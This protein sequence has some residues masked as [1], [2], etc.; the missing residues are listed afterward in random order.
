MYIVYL[1]RGN[2]TRERE[3]SRGIILFNFF[4]AENDTGQDCFFPSPPE[5]YTGCQYQ[6]INFVFDLPYMSRGRQRE[7][8]M[9]RYCKQYAGI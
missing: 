8:A 2:D 9:C 4:V 5:K 1:S 7:V 6:V 3:S